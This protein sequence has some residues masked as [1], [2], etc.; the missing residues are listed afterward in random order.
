MLNSS[1]LSKAYKNMPK[2]FKKLSK[3]HLKLEKTLQ[4]Q[5][6]VSLNE[7]TQTCGACVTLKEKESKL[8]L[9]I[10]TTGREKLLFLRTFRSWKIN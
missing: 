10:E 3:D 2:D 8:C 7:Y 9:E 6:D 5:V 4:D 1:I